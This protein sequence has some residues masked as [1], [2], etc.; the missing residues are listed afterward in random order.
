MKLTVAVVA[1]NFPAHIAELDVLAGGARHLRLQNKYKKR[2]K[3]DNI[4][5]GQKNKETNVP[6]CIHHF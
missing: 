3:N 1:N 6:Y 2:M 5:S 4:Y